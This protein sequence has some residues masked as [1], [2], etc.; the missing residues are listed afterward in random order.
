M[1]NDRH[2]ETFEPVAGLHICANGTGSYVKKED[3]EKIEKENKE[4]RGSEYRI[5]RMYAEA[6]NKDVYTAIREGF[7]KFLGIGNTAIIA[8]A[9]LV[10]IIDKHFEEQER[11]NY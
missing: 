5:T 1:S 8:L 9:E 4:I 3:Y 7:P 6:I 10:H 11:G 2:I